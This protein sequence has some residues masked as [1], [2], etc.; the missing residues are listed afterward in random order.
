MLPRNEPANSTA[1]KV[2]FNV[3]FNV[4]RIINVQSFT[5]HIVYLNC[6]HKQR[7]S[8]YEY[9]LHIVGNLRL[10]TSRLSPCTL[11]LFLTV[12]IPSPTKLRRDIV[13]LPFVLGLP[14]FRNILVNTL[15]S[16]SFNEF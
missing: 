4:Q 1:D 9:T 3:L 11:L 12:I 13:T 2:F 16:T 14:S 7:T 8:L 5:Y 10:I 6:P 15:E